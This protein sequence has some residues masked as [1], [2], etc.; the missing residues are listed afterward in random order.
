MGRWYHKVRCAQM[1]QDGSAEQCRNPAAGGLYCKRHAQARQD[2]ADAIADARGVPY[3]FRESVM[4][5][6]A[7]RRAAER[8][9]REFTVARRRPQ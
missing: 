5:A 9:A 6:A 2:V 4:R 1:R 8:D 7:K 3:E